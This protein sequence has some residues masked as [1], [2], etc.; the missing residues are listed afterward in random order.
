MSD[1]PGLTTGYAGMEALP[2][3]AMGDAFARLTSNPRC[4]A[5]EESELMNGVNAVTLSIER[6]QAARKGL[7]DMNAGTSNPVGALPPSQ[8]G[9]L[10]SPT[11]H[12]REHLR[13]FIVSRSL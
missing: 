7:R 5:R 10:G 2:G 12:V 8:G 4:E 11:R 6:Y 1:P 9:G 3:N 13:F